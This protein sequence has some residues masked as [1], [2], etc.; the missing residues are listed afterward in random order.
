MGMPLS[1]S[2]A[3]A[4]V[5]KSQRSRFGKATETR[6]DD[7]VRRSWELNPGQF[8]LRNPSWQDAVADLVLQVR[9][10]LELP[11]SGIVRA[12]LYKLLLYE[13]GAFFKP[14][15]D[16]EK[17]P[18]MFGT[19]IVALPSAHQ[20]GEISLRHQRETLN[21]AT[22]PNSGFG[23]SWAAWY[24]CVEAPLREGADH[25]RY[26]DVVHEVLP[27]TQ[28]WRLVLTYN[29]VMH[30][31]GGIA[32]PVL[33]SSS[34]HGSYLKS[35]LRQWD[36]DLRDDP[37]GLPSFLIH[38]LAHQYTQANLSLECLKGKDR[39]QVRYLATVAEEVGTSLFLANM[40]R[41]IVRD[42]E[43]EHEENEYIDT[44]VTLKSI[45]TL[46]GVV[47]GEKYH[48]E[49]DNLLRRVKVDLRAADDVEL[50]GYTGNEGCT[51]TYWY[52]DTVRAAPDSLV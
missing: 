44:S 2:D 34:A 15:Q 24:V 13:E 42:D 48:A 47:I 19:L 49:D 7:S 6:L 41:G 36:A 1:V 8:A 26:S 16:S 39:A 18:G 30:R 5:S 10:R 33:P 43:E 27:V 21:I 51:A 23:F 17:T 22:A 32:A 28:G 9:E 25:S 12:E 31:D 50:S 4:I 38:R 35:L 46:S 29:L 20:G 40:Q 45:T 11:S 3:E 52:R 37:D 14:H